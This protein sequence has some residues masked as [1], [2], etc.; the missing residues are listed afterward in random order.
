MLARYAGNDNPAILAADMTHVAVLG[1]NSTDE[2]LNEAPGIVATV[3]T[4][5]QVATPGSWTT[6]TRSCS[7]GRAARSTQP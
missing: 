7:R 1:N 3:V 5:A 4:D 6:S 2:E